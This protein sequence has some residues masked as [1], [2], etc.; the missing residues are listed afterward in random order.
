VIEVRPK[1]TGVFGFVFVV[2]MFVGG[3][4]VR[5]CASQRSPFLNT[6]SMLLSK[7]D[8]WSATRIFSNHYES[9]QKFYPKG[10]DW[11]LH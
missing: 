3:E 7:R 6:D 10:P 5:S 4:S 8:C 2:L 11:S 1:R 9:T